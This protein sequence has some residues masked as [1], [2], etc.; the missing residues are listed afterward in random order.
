M[1]KITKPA[2]KKILPKKPLPKEESPKSLERYFQA[3]GRRKTSSAR[4]RFFVSDEKEIIV[5]DKPFQVYFPTLELQGIVLSPLNI[6]SVDKFRILIKVN[7][8]GIHSQ[9]EAVRHGISRALVLTNQDSRKRLKKVGFLTRD[10]RMR[11]RKKFGLKRA[12]RAP[13][14]RKR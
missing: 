5:N 4:I 3:I 1:P 11:E 12:R 14:W 7:G 9:A 6:M 2:V 13:Q 10:S 8:G